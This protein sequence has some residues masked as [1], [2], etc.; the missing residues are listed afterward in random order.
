MRAVNE[1]V[2]TD[3]LYT[4]SY[5]KGPKSQFFE[6]FLAV[7]PYIWPLAG[8]NIAKKGLVVTKI[9]EGGSTKPFWN[10]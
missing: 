5:I 1:D 9:G 10:F 4:I 2:S 8:P 6:Y 7:F 3:M